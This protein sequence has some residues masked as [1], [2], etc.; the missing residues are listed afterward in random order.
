MCA[1]RSPQLACTSSLVSPKLPAVNLREEQ[2]VWTLGAKIRAE[3]GRRKWKVPIF[4]EMIGAP[5]KTVYRWVNDKN[6]PPAEMIE[7]IAILF[8]WPPSYLLRSDLPYPPPRRDRAWIEGVLRN[9]TQEAL[10]VVAHLADPDMALYLSEQAE[11]F[12]KMRNRMSG[13]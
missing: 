11:A 10:D 12:L 4:S 9:L 3:L 5:D 2:F 8:G 7:S 6:I 13:R 1:L